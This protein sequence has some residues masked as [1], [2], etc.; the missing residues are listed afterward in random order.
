MLP[1]STLSVPAGTV[2]TIA[3]EPP[4]T[5]SGS[6]S[7]WE[8][9]DD[10]AEGELPAGTFDYENYRFSVNA[11][12]VAETASQQRFHARRKL[13][14]L[15]HE[16][17]VDLGLTNWR[18]LE[19]WRLAALL[20]LA[21]W[22]RLYVHYATQWVYLRGSR[23]AVYDFQPQWTTCLVKY[24]W[25]SV[26][27]STEVATLALGVLGNTALFAFLALC[28]A[29]SQRLVGE[30]PSFGSSLI[31]CVGL[32]TLLDPFLVLA[33]DVVSHHYDCS[34][35]TECATSLGA[36]DC[37]CVIGDWFKLYVRFQA[38]EGSG[39]VGVFLVLVVYAALSSVTLVALYIYLLYVHMN[40]RML[41]VYRRVHAQEQAFFVPHDAELSLPELRVVCEAA[42]RWKGPRGTQRKVFVH[43]YVLS[44][45]LDAG[46]EEK[47][48]HVAIY[49]VELDGQRQL[50]RHF[51][52]SSDGAVLELFGE[53]GTGADGTWQ[54]EAVGGASSSLAMLYN[55][56]QEHQGEQDAVPLSTM[57]DA[58]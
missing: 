16:L 5:E 56:L 23:V 24:T 48:A 39:L 22:L 57:F 30:L 1:S 37:R 34:S 46:F 32:A 10:E 38:L 40:G 17:L 3:E 14:Y 21:C 9:S 4:A 31:V 44:D 51:L 43:E 45:P 2:K 12:A 54:D 36:A 27:T 6:D 20:L 13:H 26:A 47:T 49:N 19:F 41:D 28:A 52:R 55:I 8:F 58:L 42:R 7:D 25:R 15:R 50:H 35:L 33:V 11:A 29:L 18:T 53:V